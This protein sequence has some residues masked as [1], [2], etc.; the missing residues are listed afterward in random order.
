MNKN[1]RIFIAGHK[2]L[3]GSAISRNLQNNGYSNLLTADKKDL[4]LTDANAVDKYFLENKI[5][6]VFDAAA[7]VGGIKA[8]NDHPAEFITQNIK[9][10]TNL[11]ESASKYK[12]KKFL[13][14]GSS[15][16]YPKFA[17]QPI[18]EDQLLTGL[19][20]ETNEAY[21]IAKI[22]GIKM[23]Q[24]FRKQY[25]LNAI[26]LMPTNLYGPGDNYHPQN[27]HVLPAMIRRFHE[28][29]IKNLPEVTCWGDGSPKR[30]FLYVDDLAE[31][32]LLCMLNYESKE[33][34]NI[35]TGRDITIRELAGT[36]AKAVGYEGE[37]KWDNTASINGT[38][39]KVLNV[40]KIPRMGSQDR[41]PHRN[42]EHIRGLPL[43]KFKKPSI[44]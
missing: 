42:Q 20:E 19:L 38:P 43:A 18:A 3:V 11:I 24:A 30:E 13:F 4:D 14:L 44:I 29:K 31:A 39:R 37:I 12:I 32:C 35:G 28:A 25:G 40:N 27:S 36:V 33:I 10:Q 16:I 5:E 7:K 41:P 15:C 34:I 8:N 2:G 6:Y 17:S 21:A 23:C 9:I 22:C 1:S 26:S